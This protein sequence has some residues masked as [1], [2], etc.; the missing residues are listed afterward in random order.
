MTLLRAIAG[1]ALVLSLAACQ[2]S[3]YKP[4]SENLPQLNV[5]FADSAWNGATIPAGQ[6]CSLFGGKG[7]TPA[8]QVSGIPDGANAVIV[9]FNDRDY[10]PLSSGG[11]HG[12]IGYPVSGTSAS[13]PSVPGET[14]S[15]TG[16]AWV[17]ANSRGTGAYAKSGYLPPCS[18]GKGNRYF[19]VVKAVY[20]AAKDGEESKLLATSTIEL[21]KY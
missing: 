7:A 20:K 19:A 8:L 13:L 5:S 4:V 2:T 3:G 15:L 14:G 9:E 1:S 6:Q 11:G 18:G 21:G 10:S 12:I 16:G 17:E